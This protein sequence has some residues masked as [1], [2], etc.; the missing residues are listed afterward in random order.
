MAEEEKEEEES[1][2]RVRRFQMGLVEEERRR[3]D[4]ELE[5]RDL[6]RATRK[7]MAAFELRILTE[8]NRA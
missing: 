1:R 5:D 8:Q 7:A 3:E 4:W 2:S 6:A